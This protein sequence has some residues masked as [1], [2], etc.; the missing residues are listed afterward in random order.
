[1]DY[2]KRVAIAVKCLNSIITLQ[3]ADIAVI[4]AVVLT[5][6]IFRPCACQRWG[7]RVLNSDYLF[8][9]RTIAG[10]IFNIIGTCDSGWANAVCICINKCK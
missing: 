4:E 9:G 10:S 8:A 6:D 3:A 1:M 2:R 5:C 7:D